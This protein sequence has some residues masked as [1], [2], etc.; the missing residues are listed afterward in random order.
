MRAPAFT[1]TAFEIAVGGG[2]ATIARTQTISVHRQTH[3]AA[4][5]TPL[6]ACFNE[7]LVQTFFFGLHLHEAGARH[8]QSLHDI[9]SHLLAKLLDDV[10]RR[11][12]VLDAGVRAGTD[13]DV[14]GLDVGDLGA[15][16]EI[17]VLKR[18][19]LTFAL[20]RIHFLFGI[21]HDAVN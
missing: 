10:C 14:I 4:R 9:G 20:Y 8:N 21:G 11:T 15:G 1:L 17:H 19:H 6:K 7:D 3:R 5:F 2:G 13:E 12:Y 18:A 16:H